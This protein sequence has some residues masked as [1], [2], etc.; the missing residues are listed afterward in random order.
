MS[1]TQE[2]LRNY[3]PGTLRTGSTRPVCTA[4]RV[5]SRPARSQTAIHL[6]WRKI[7]P[8][9]HTDTGWAGLQIPLQPLP[10]VAR[11]THE[12]SQLTHRCSTVSKL[13]E[14]EAA[15]SQGF[16][17]G[18]VPSFT[19]PPSWSIVLAK[20][21]TSPSRSTHT[22]YPQAAGMRCSKE[23]M[24]DE[25]DPTTSARVLGLRSC[26]SSRLPACCSL[27][28]TSRGILFSTDFMRFDLRCMHSGTATKRLIHSGELVP[29]R[30]DWISGALELCQRS[31]QV[32][33]VLR[34]GT[35][36]TSGHHQL[37]PFE[38]Q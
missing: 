29:F 16:T 20:P 9:R 25:N 22:T 3:T 15:V 36:K 5:R 17:S 38:V 11:R 24:A 13:W 35:K 28:C 21:V 2:T 27:C 32:Y 30:L 33:G 6:T 18:L 31:A 26:R 37:Q 10:E 1:V 4:S 14:Y 23:N 8:E 34:I 12:T 7:E 19:W